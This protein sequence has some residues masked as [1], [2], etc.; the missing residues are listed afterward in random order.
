MTTPYLDE[1]TVTETITQVIADFGPDHIYAHA[2]DNNKACYYEL[3]DPDED[4]TYRCIAGEVLHRLVDTDT[5][6]DIVDFHNAS[7]VLMLASDGRINVD[8]RT[9]RALNRAQ[10]VQDAGETWGEALDAY[11]VILSWDDGRLE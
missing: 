8:D 1:D 7:D 6:A 11:H 9:L 4:T 5:W 10:R 2:S 3:Y